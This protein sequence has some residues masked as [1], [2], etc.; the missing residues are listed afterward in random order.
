MKSEPKIL[1]IVEGKK[2]EPA[3][4]QCVGQVFNLDF[5]IYCLKTNIYSLYKEMKA[6]DFNADIRD[7][8]KEMHPEYSEVLSDRFAYT[9]LIFDLDPHHPK[10]NESRSI[11][12]IIIENCSRIREMAAYFVDETDPAVGKLYINYPMF[13]SFRACDAPFD[14]AF[15]TEYVSLPDIKAFKTYVGS[16]KMVRRHLKD[17]TQNDFELLTKMNIFKLG[18]L[19]S[20]EWEPIPYLKYLEYSSAQAILAKQEKSISS[21]GNIATLNTSLFLLVDYY[22]NRD[23]Y[24]DRIINLQ[25]NI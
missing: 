4:F 19:F 15:R 5:G 18:S 2:T 9:Y 10:K 12:Q 13:E 16:K 1:I 25:Q 23:G 17:Y 8:L 6:L 20:G 3:F 11:T 7:V 21:A 22:G 14:P 24:Y